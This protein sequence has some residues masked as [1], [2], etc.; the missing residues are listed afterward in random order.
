MQELVC[1]S[2]TERSLPMS[3]TYSSDTAEALARL[4]LQ[5]DTDDAPAAPAAHQEPPEADPTPLEDAGIIT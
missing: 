4:R 3:S 5:L 1:M 2:K